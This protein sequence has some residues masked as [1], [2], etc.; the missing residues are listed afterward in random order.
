MLDRFLSRAPTT[1]STPMGEDKAS[2]NST[3]HEAA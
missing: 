2:G 3:A 1:P